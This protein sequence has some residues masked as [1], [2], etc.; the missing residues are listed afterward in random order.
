MLNNL[1][2]L[3]RAPVFITTN[4][5][6]PNPEFRFYLD[7]NGNGMFDTNGTVTNLVYTWWIASDSTRWQR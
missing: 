6:Q 2:Y 1:L 7:E 5:N 4:R 3:P